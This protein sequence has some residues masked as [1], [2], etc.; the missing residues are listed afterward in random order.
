M[1]W[2][3][4]LIYFLMHSQFW[5]Y[6]RQLKK[7]AT[8][9]RMALECRKNNSEIFSMN[10]QLAHNRW[11]ALSFLGG[12]CISPWFALTL[13]S[14]A[15]QGWWLACGVDSC[16]SGSSSYQPIIRYLFSKQYFVKELCSIILEDIK[17]E[18]Q[19]DNTSSQLLIYFS[20]TVN[21][22]TILVP[23]KEN[24]DYIVTLSVR[25]DINTN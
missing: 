15:C 25:E 8:S 19:H 2:E 10:L 9:Y 5:P 20:C 12:P 17:K 14:T 18:V 6:L 4:L 13:R 1:W 21:N 22:G 11:W 24:S 7:V 3:W 16:A 23:Q